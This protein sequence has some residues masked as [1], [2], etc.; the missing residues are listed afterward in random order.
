M[1]INVGADVCKMRQNNETPTQV[2]TGGKE[3]DL[4]L[5]DLTHPSEPIFRAKNVSILLLF[6]I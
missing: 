4:K 3:N 5:W 1:K 6:S 2:A